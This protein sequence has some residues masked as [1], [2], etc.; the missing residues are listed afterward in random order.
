MNLHF[1]PLDRSTGMIHR[2]GYSSRG[3]VRK[4]VRIDTDEQQRL[5]LDHAEFGAT[6]RASTVPIAPVTDWD[7]RD[8]CLQPLGLWSGLQNLVGIGCKRIAGWA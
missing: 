7:R 3:N 1:A 8:T 2:V 6:P 5:S 4:T